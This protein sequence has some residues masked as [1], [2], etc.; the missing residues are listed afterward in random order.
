MNSQWIMVVFVVLA[1]SVAIAPVYWMRP[2]ARQRQLARLREYALTLGLRPELSTVPEAM[3]RAG[4]ADRLMKYQWHRPTGDWPRHG[5]VWLAL[6]LPADGPK[7]KCCWPDRGQLGGPDV[8][9]QALQEEMPEGLFAIEASPLG[10]GFYW[11][12]AGDSDRVDQ[13]FQHLQPW[14]EPYREAFSE[15]EHEPLGPDSAEGW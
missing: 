5:D 15:R 10:L 14:V 12:E 6:L 9:L 4:Y 1:I 7:Q 8:L 11:H 3:Q 2:S 13:L